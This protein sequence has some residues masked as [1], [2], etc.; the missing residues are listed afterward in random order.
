VRLPARS[1]RRSDD[2]CKLIDFGLAHVYQRNEAGEVVRE[3]LKVLCG[4][5]SYAAPEVLA[6]FGYDGPPVDVWSLGV[7]LFGML[8]GFFPLEEAN[9]SDWRYAKAHEETRSG[10]SMTLTIFGLYGR[11]CPLSAEAIEAIDSMLAPPPESRPTAEQMLRGAFCEQRTLT[12]EQ[13]DQALRRGAFQLQPKAAAPAAQPSG[14]I[15]GASPVVSFG[16]QESMAMSFDFGA[17]PSCGAAMEGPIY[18][19]STPYADGGGGP[20]VYRA[21]SGATTG[22]SAP[23]IGVAPIGAMPKLTKQ[24]AFYEADDAPAPIGLA[25]GGIDPYR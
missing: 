24:M 23:A 6:G 22:G 21:C 4:S 19:G 3:P 14:S 9:S 18:R 16:A 25:S 13:T 11:P 7:C 5:K 8:A 20:P 10:A 1:P 12:A 2:R 15:P 17:Q